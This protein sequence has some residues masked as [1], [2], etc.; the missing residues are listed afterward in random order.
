M[1]LHVE[2]G[3]LSSQEHNLKSHRKVAGLLFI[4]LTVKV[5]RSLLNWKCRISSFQGM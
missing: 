1:F 3:V 4:H 2:V 5:S